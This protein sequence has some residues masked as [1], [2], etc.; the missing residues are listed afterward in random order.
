MRS[1]TRARL[2]LLLSAVVLAA[3]CSPAS[4]G[5]R[6]D[7]ASAER[8]TRP[9]FVAEAK[10]I[11]RQLDDK[12]HDFKDPSTFP[13]E[14]K[15]FGG[16]ADRYLASV[17][18]EIAQLSKLTPPAELEQQWKDFTGALSKSIRQA[19]FTA[20]LVASKN[21]DTDALWVSWTENKT[22]R[23]RAME[24]AAD[25]QLGACENLQ[26]AHHH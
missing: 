9:A 3:A 7:Q 20:Q 16:A 10:P 21:D 26:A 6:A 23:A 4:S 2:Y 22:A 19:Q 8:P 15:D 14:L 24:L 12:L 11:C 5:S 1:R 18:G 13:A 25:M 17:G